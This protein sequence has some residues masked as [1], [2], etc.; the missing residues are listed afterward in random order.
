MRIKPPERAYSFSP[1]E[2]ETL[3]LCR[4]LGFPVRF[5]IVFER[6]GYTYSTAKALVVEGDRLILWEK[7]RKRE[8]SLKSLY[9][10]LYRQFGRGVRLVPQPV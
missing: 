5:N 10:R 6:G 8:G 1:M 2:N 7:G 4:E 9:E 3:K